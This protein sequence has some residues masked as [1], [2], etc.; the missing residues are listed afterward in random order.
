MF[1]P[2]LVDAQR[3]KNIKAGYRYFGTAVRHGCNDGR[4]LRACE[5]RNGNLGRRSLARSFD[6]VNA[7][8]SDFP[9]RLLA[10]LLLSLVVRGRLDSANAAKI[11]IFT[12][13][14]PRFVLGWTGLVGWV[15][16]IPT[17]TAAIFRFAGS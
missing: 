3:V 17:A 4:L 13:L 5:G 9:I 12:A 16:S 7:N 1:E 11:P 15:I 14:L 8:S 2:I 6:F 10:R